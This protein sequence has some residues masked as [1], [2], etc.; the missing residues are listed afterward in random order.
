MA[1]STQLPGEK[2]ARGR[3]LGSASKMALEAREKAQ[4]TG[5]LPHEFLLRIVRGEPIYRDH[6]D[7][8][9]NTRR[10]LEVYDFEDRKDAAKAVAPYYAPK[11]STVEVIRGVPDDELDSIIAKLATETGFSLG[12]GGKGTEDEAEENPPRRTRVSLRE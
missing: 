7:R 10:V 5:D 1:L 2:R 12:D 6:V 4:A 9:G 8:D 3:P 11:I